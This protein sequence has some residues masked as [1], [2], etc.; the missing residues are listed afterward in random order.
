MNPA[1]APFIAKAVGGMASLVGLAISADWWLVFAQQETP[2]A[3]ITYGV[4]GVVTAAAAWATI[5]V[6]RS[7]S[8]ARE[9]DS[10]SYERLQ[11]RLAEAEGREQELRERAEAAE[12]ARN[13]AEGRA[14]RYMARLARHGLDPESTGETPTQD[15]G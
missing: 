13:A 7:F 6:Y 11:Q 3:P 1:A 14:I 9:F 8:K 2:A 5:T 4:A 12:R 10:E 15:A